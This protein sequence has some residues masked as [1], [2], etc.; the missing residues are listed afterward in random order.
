MNKSSLFLVVALLV[1]VSELYA[2][3]S[4]AVEGETLLEYLYR[5]AS[6]KP[7]KAPTLFLLHGYGSNENDMHQI[8]IHL[9]AEYN[10]I[11]V[12][13]PFER[14]K[15]SYAWYEVSFEEGKPNYNA[16]QMLESRELILQFIDQM[17]K[18]LE[19]DRNRL[20]LGGFSQ[21]GIMSYDI[22][23]LQPDAFNGLVIIGSRL[24]PESVETMKP[25]EELQHL[26]FFIAHGA[27]DPVLHVNY[28]RQA[29]AFLERKGVQIHYYELPDLGHSVSHEL[30]LDLNRWLA[31]NKR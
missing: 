3:P 7:H 17:V 29:K 10:V 6:F 15:D 22:G 21:G 1:W 31:K 4:D 12:R 13:A 25:M 5:P 19:L 8:A 2:K 20:F 23:L 9:F 18:K 26:K 16:D 24:A 27:Q 30:V 11:S 28:A 14:S